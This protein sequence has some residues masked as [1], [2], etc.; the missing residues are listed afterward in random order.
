MRTSITAASVSAASRGGKKRSST[1][2]G[3]WGG[4]T[5]KSKA[6]I[7]PLWIPRKSPTSES[8]D[9]DGGCFS[10]GRMMYMMIDDDAKQ[11]GQQSEGAAV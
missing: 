7:K 3:G 4:A 11:N 6:Y 10:F 9:G 5:K 2:K 8:N 1:P